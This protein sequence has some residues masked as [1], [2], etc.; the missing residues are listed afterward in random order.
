M[1][2]FNWVDVVIVLVLVAALAVVG[3]KA[4]PDKPAEVVSEDPT[5]SEPVQFEPNL[6]IEILCTELTPELADNAIDSLQSAPWDMEDIEGDMTQVFNSY[7]LEDAY[8]VA[9][10]KEESDEEGLVDLRLTMEANAVPSRGCYSIGTQEIRIGK[11]YIAKTMGIEIVGTIV[12]VTELT[13]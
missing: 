4:L 13:Q 3:V 8:F 10:E 9:W 7:K 2:R 6:R 5:A 12:A 1:K 11:S